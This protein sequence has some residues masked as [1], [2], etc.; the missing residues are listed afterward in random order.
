MFNVTTKVT[1]KVLTITVD[2]SKV[3][4]PSASGKSEIIAS[5]QGNALLEGGIKL[6]LNVYRP[7]GSEAK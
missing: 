7:V 1:G 5:T 3:L 4:G 2:T 6:G